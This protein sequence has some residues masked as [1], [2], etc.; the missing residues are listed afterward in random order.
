MACSLLHIWFQGSCAGDVSFG[1]WLGE[2]RSAEVRV[3]LWCDR[4]CGP[5]G[6]WCQVSKR[7]E[8]DLPIE[9]DYARENVLFCSEYG[10]SKMMP[11]SL[12]VKLFCKSPSAFAMSLAT[13]SEVRSLNGCEMIR[14]FPSAQFI[15]DQ[16]K[17]CAYLPTAALNM[18]ILYQIACSL[19]LSVT[20]VTA[21]PDAKQAFEKYI[22]DPAGWWG[23]THGQHHPRLDRSTR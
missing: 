21:V 22:K 1:D 2:K 4:C 6:R 20:L 7:S 11:T 18:A 10:H 13:W 3:A 19:V 12:K 5:I 16:G 23:I 17:S 15:W 9:E 8:A 14:S